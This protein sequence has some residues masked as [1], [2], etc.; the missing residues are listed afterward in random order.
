MTRVLGTTVEEQTFTTFSA[1]KSQHLAT[2]IVPEAAVVVI[3]R[4]LVS[5]NYVATL[6]DWQSVKQKERNEWLWYV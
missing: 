4:R 3:W 2:W 1:A 6:S 5:T